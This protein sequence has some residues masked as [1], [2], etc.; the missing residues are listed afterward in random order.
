M[1]RWQAVG[2]PSIDRVCAW[3]T[4]VYHAALELHRAAGRTEISD[5]IVD[6][7]TGAAGPRARPVKDYQIQV[8]AA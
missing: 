8:L 5:S 2:P 1:G 4:E 7:G 3:E 6:Q